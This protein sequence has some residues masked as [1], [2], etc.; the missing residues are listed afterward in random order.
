MRY[1]TAGA[2]QADTSD[3]PSGYWAAKPKA[4]IAPEIAARIIQHYEALNEGGFIDLYRLT[5]TTYYGLDGAGRHATSKVMEFGEQ[6][7]KLG[8]RSNQMRSLT[9]YVHLTATQNKPAI[10]PRAQ[11]STPAAL[12]QIPTARRVLEYYDRKANMGAVYDS[13]AL[14]A[15]LMGKGYVVQMWDPFAGPIEAPKAPEQAAQP[16]SP[17]AQPESPA[18]EQDFGPDGPP[19]RPPVQEAAAPAQAKPTGDLTAVAGSPLTVACDLDVSNNQHDWFAVRIRRNRYDQIALYA[20]ISPETA[21]DPKAVMSANEMRERLLAA[22]ADILDEGLVKK[23]AFWNRKKSR[24]RADSVFEYHWMH[25][26]TPAM[27][28]GRYTVITADSL[29]LFDGPL[30]YDTL[31]VDVMCPEEFLEMGDVGY[32]SAWD[33][34]GM[35][36]IYDA[37][38]SICATNMDAFGTNDLMIPE[39]VELGMEEVR[40]GLNV[41]RY[42]MGEM[43]KPEIL[44]KFSIKKEFFEFKDWIKA[45]METTLGVNSVARGEPQASLESGAA[46]ALVQAQ[47]VTSQAPFIKAYNNL[48]ANASSTQIK[49]LQRHLP[50][51][52]VIA[53][54]GSDDPDSIQA[55]CAPSIDQIDRIDV[56]GVNP[57]FA[58]S[59]GKQNAADKLLERGLITS[60]FAYVQF[61]ETGRLENA[62][63]EARQKDLFGRRV[64]EILMTGPA[65]S[66]IPGP[67]DP[68]TGMPGQPK[69]I[70][71]EC[72]FVITHD[73][74]VCAEAAA[75]VLG[76]F[77][78]MKDEKVVQ[79]ATVYLADV[80]QT[81]RATDPDTL[82]L[83][84]FPLPSAAMARAQGLPPDLGAV[85]KPAAPGAPQKPGQPPK[86]AAGDPAAKPQDAKPPAAG[87]SMPSLPKPAENPL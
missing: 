49:I 31:P 87:G 48:V 13:A 60:P 30:P 67:V 84:G 42:P 16:E 76:S 45:D 75:S 23:L 33:L 54:A 64:K 47:A 59:A 2:D 28:E 57:L 65:V 37:A 51:D 77:E 18:P 26:K 27:P 39:G 63:D 72:R 3:V 4:E 83:F 21:Q 78:L 9:K 11:N 24:D 40:D 41:I 25:R 46:L 50:K 82:T 34:L 62:T 86:S 36:A 71:P 29:V 58:T 12:A 68:M 52:R 15:L 7:E 19:I 80:L 35:Q 44:E 43:N 53:I 69:Q 5:H 73:P 32:S 74:R 22:P 66:E 38:M 61:Q 85:N 56:E 1:D 20:S 17:E 81:W 70:V 10:K 14:I 79:A 6:G 55:F 8:V